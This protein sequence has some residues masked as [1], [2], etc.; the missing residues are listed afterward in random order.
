MYVWVYYAINRRTRAE[1][2]RRA[3]RLL[4]PRALVGH[5]RNVVGP[6]PIAVSA[7]HRRSLDTMRA[8]RIHVVRRTPPS[9]YPEHI[10]E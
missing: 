7:V 1:L 6:R 8:A 3:R 2:A 9:P 4:L 10:Q 5:Q